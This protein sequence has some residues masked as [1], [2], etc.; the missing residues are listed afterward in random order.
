MMIRFARASWLQRAEIPGKGHRVRPLLRRPAAPKRPD[1][2]ALQGRHGSARYAPSMYKRVT[3]RAPRE[4]AE[5]MSWYF[6]S[7]PIT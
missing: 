6:I 2:E 7:I 4:K 3:C 5:R 1:W